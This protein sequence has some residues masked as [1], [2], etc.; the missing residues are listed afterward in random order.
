MK[1]AGSQKL[2]DQLVRSCQDYA[3]RRHKI[4][5]RVF[6]AKPVQITR[7]D[8]SKRYVPCVD[9]GW[10]DLA[11]VIPP[12]GRLVAAEVKTGSS[13]PRPT[14]AECLM[15]LASLGAHVAVVH[16]I[17]EFIT[18]F[19]AIMIHELSGVLG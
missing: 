14:Q 19:D 15:D 7:R 6:E 5:L 17:D 10:P 1:H 18:W 12:K 2:H 13:R 9:A 3:L 4:R 8:G 11:G 16:S